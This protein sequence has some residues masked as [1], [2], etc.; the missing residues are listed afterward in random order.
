M[1][2]IASSVGEDD[3]GIIIGAFFGDF[4]GGEVFGVEFGIEENL[5]A[6]EGR[7]GSGGDMHGLVDA[8]CVL[9]AGSGGDGISE[10]KLGDFVG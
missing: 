6:G 2:R 1:E 10:G 4:F 3:F 9:D 5:F 8:T 7:V